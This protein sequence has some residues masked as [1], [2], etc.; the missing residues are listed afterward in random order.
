[1]KRSP[2]KYGGTRGGDR[3]HAVRH[4]V[5]VP[6]CPW[7]KRNATARAKA[8]MDSFKARADDRCPTCDGLGMLDT[9]TCPETGYHDGP[10]CPSC[11]GNGK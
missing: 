4:A 2:V 11:K 6:W 9:V 3:S 1:M 5:P 10:R 7:C 8:A